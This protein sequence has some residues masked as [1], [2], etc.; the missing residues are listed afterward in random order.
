MSSFIYLC[1]SVN[2]LL[3]H[4]ALNRVFSFLVGGWVRVIIYLGMGLLFE[5]K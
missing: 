3:I 4:V 2:Q 5:K 1:G